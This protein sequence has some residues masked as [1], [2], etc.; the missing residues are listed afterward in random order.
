[1]PRFSHIYEE[2]RGELPLFSRWLLAWGRAVDAHGPLVFGAFALFVAAAVWALRRPAVRSSLGALVWSIAPL[3]DR[4][5]LYQLSRFYRTVGMLLR[6]GVP[7]LAALGMAAELLHPLLRE[8]LTVAMQAISEGHGVSHSMDS[9]GLTTPVALRM[10]AVGEKSGNMGEMLESIAQ[11]HDEELGRWVEWFTR[12]FEPILM[13]IIGLV[14]G[15]IVL[16]MYMPI[17]ELVGAVQ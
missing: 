14:I 6:G 4:L 12:L 9:N 2:G 13:V 7:L 17:F 15:V 11:F 8:R 16:L 5:K 3:Q 1:V 10:L